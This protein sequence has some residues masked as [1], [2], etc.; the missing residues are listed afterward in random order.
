MFRR[1]ALVGSLL[2]VVGSQP[3]AAVEIVTIDSIPGG[4]QPRTR[5]ATLGERVRWVNNDGFAHTS[6]NGAPLSLW[7]LSLP[8][9]QADRRVFAEAGTFPYLCQIHPAMTGVIR[10]AI[11]VTPAQ[12]PRGTTFTVR[13]G[14]AAP[15]AGF[16]YVIQR[17]R[18]N[19]A[20]FTDWRTINAATTTFVTTS[21]TA[22]GVWRF[23]SRLRRVANGA[24]SGF[25]PAD[26]ITIR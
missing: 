2:V 9:G 1:A 25:S 20:S 14:S 19:A 16:R 6:T 7:N 23:R 11:V 22:R 15:P 12:G 21:S 18:P 3:A 4:F 17:R 10:V 24:Q 13:A 26:T 5:T 8:A